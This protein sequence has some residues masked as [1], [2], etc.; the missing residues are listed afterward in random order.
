VLQRVAVCSQRLVLVQ[1]FVGY[2][3]LQRVAVCCRVLYRVAGVAV[4]SQIL[5]LGI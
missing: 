4:C 2:S 1:L 5:L 3:V